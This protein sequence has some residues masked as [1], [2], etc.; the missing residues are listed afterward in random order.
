M[1]KWEV[2]TGEAPGSLWASSSGLCSTAAAE[3][4][5]NALFQQ[6]GR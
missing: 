4:V 3:T 2:G 6:D 1:V 5:R